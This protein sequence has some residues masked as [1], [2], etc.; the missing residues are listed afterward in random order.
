ME[1]LVFYAVSPSKMLEKIVF[2]EEIKGT[3]CKLEHK[4][5]SHSLGNKVTFVLELTDHACG[6]RGFWD[7]VRHGRVAE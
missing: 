3:S 7:H 4:R 1:Q 6:Q 5:H 2:P